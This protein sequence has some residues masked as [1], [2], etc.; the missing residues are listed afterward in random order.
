MVGGDNARRGGIRLFDVLQRRPLNKH[1]MY[2]LLD[3][4][5]SALFPELAAAR[6]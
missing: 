4:L 3:E 2:T 6:L 1:L 5:V